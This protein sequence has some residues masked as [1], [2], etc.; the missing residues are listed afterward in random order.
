MCL[1]TN[2]AVFGLVWYWCLSPFIWYFLILLHIQLL[3]HYCVCAHYILTHLLTHNDPPPYFL[4]GI[5]FATIITNNNITKSNQFKNQIKLTN[6]WHHPWIVRRYD[7][8]K[9]YR[10]AFWGM[11][12][13]CLNCD[14]E[15]R[16]ISFYPPNPISGSNRLVEKK[17]DWKKNGKKKITEKKTNTS[18]TKKIITRRGT[19]RIRVDNYNG[20]LNPIKGDLVQFAACPGPGER[21]NMRYVLLYVW[22]GRYVCNLNHPTDS[23]N[24]ISFSEGKLSVLVGRTFSTRTFVLVYLFRFALYYFNCCLLFVILYV[25]SSCSNVSVSDFLL[26]SHLYYIIFNLHFRFFHSLWIPWKYGLYHRL[27]LQPVFKSILTP[28]RPRSTFQYWGMRNGLMG[29]L[30]CKYDVDRTINKSKKGVK[31]GRVRCLLSLLEKWRGRGKHFLFVSPPL[32]HFCLS[33]ISFCS[34]LSYFYAFIFTS[35]FSSLIFWFLIFTRATTLHWLYY[36][37]P[38]CNIKYFPLLVLF[39]QLSIQLSLLN[40]YHAIHNYAI[41]MDQDGGVREVWNGWMSVQPC[42]PHRE[43]RIE[44]E[45]SEGCVDT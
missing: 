38:N 35:F 40:K 24:A 18:T 4:V 33:F 34:L 2:N 42:I 15:D 19:S 5:L 9:G 23:N 16:A 43:E 37:L 7:L 21:Q 41:G 1:D 14:V 22:C 28:P 44:R 45:I 11:R 26:S 32:F 13:Q 36:K 29:G 30:E 31:S 10:I 12:G 3:Y 20:V 8:P 27:D 6:I 17:P 25:S 39:S